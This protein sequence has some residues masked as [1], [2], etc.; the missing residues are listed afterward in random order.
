MMSSGLH[1]NPCRRADLKNPHPDGSFCNP[2][3]F[4]CFACEK[5]I[6]QGHVMRTCSLLK[7]G[8]LFVNPFEPGFLHCTSQ[9]T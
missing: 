2:C 1:D 9:S 7:H 4:D 8:C 6:G 5:G 3:Q